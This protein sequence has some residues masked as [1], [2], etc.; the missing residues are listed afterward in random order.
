MASVSGPRCDKCA[1]GYQGEFPDCQPCHQCFATW[2]RVVEELT[3]Q[4]RRLEAKVTELQTS[5]VTAPYQDLVTSL[6]TNV[7]TVTEIV[8]SNPAAMKLEEIQDLMHQ[9]TYVHK[10][11]TSCPFIQ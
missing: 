5:G 6:E 4:T 8:Q 9:I 7:K 10:G 11:C 3:N 2:D 1:R